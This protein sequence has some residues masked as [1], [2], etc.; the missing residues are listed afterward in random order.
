MK[1]S[2]FH[3][4]KNLTARPLLSSM[5]S[6]SRLMAH[7][8]EAVTNPWL[9]QTMVDDLASFTKSV[10]TQWRQNKL[11]HIDASD[12]QASL[13]DETLRTTLPVLWKLLKSSLFTTVIVL[14]SVLGRVLNDR[15]LAADASMLLGPTLVHVT[16]HSASGSSCSHSSPPHPA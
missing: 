13:H 11:S 3:Q 7:A 6:L 10:A 15:V 12:E 9:I 14:K 4:V 1:S 8:A 16:D 2:S 5:G